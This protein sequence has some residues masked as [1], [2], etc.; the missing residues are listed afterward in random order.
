MQKHASVS[1]NR[2]ALAEIKQHEEAESD[3]RSQDYA[4]SSSFRSYSRDQAVDTG[5]LCSRRSDPSV[6][7]RQCFSLD[8]KVLIDRIRLC[9]HAIDRTMALVEPSPFL[10]HVF[11]FRFGRI[12]TSKSVNVGPDIRQ[13]VLT[14]A[15][16]SDGGFE[17]SE[18]LAMLAQEFAMAGEVVLFQRRGV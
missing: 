17:P 10:Q 7:A 4:V 12:G 8:A 16:F 13:E 14:V 15:S 5:Y 6:D 18:F 3:E 1:A 2:S 9:Q 11:G